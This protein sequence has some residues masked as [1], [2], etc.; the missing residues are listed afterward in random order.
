MDR[1]QRAEK[2]KELLDDAKVTLETL[3][4]DAG[5]S[6]STL[7]QAIAPKSAENLSVLPDYLRRIA[8]ALE[9]KTTER[10]RKI[11]AELRRLA[12]G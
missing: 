8:D 12:E 10:L 4:E 6:Y 7:R 3:A 11:A 2:A 5:L 9:K 1:K